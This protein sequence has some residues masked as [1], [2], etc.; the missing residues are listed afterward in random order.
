[1]NVFE[2]GHPHAVLAALETEHFGQRRFAFEDQ[3]G[4]LVDAR[5]PLGRR[6]GPRARH[7]NVC[8]RRGLALQ[9]DGRKDVRPGTGIVREDRKVWERGG[10]EGGAGQNNQHAESDR[11][12]S[13]AARQEPKAVPAKRL[14]A[15]G[16]PGATGSVLAIACSGVPQTCRV[17]HGLNGQECHLPVPMAGQHSLGLPFTGS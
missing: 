11:P 16:N 10:A 14:S 8:H 15:C 17:P 9:T 12:L 13:R 5:R 6:R 3:N 4:A 2:T 7:K 1:M